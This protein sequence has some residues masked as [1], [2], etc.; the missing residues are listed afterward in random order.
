[1]GSTMTAGTPR[2]LHVTTSDMSLDLLLGPQLRAFG[3]AGYEVHTASAPG[4][5]VGSLTAAGIVHHPLRHAT[6]STAPHHDLL[7]VAELY[8][9]FRAVRP[10]IV[11]T[12]NPKPGV[13]GRLAARA[14]GIPLVVN[15]QHGLYA[16]PTDRLRRRLPVYALERVAAGF[17]DIELVQ[18]EEDV[19]TLRRLRVPGGK[20]Q[21]L[22]NGIDLTRFGPDPHA[23]DAVRGELGLRGDQLLVGTI[24]RLVR[25]KG[26]GDF[27]E[28]ARSISA[29]RDDTVFVVV[30]PEDPD[31]ADGISRE[32]I[33]RAAAGGIRFLG[34]RDDPER[35]YPAFD[36]F[37]LASW[38]E[39]FPRAAMEASAA[40]TPVVA[41]DIRGCRQVV[42]DGSTGLLVPPC[43]PAALAGA[44]STL[45]DDV[46]RRAGMGRQAIDRARREFDQ[47][48]CIERT[49]A[50]YDLLATPRRARGRRDRSRAA[51]AT[52]R[53]DGRAGAT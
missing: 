17:G 53:R 8:R 45:L 7:A 47:Q 1:M 52:A 35:L 27:L 23:R 43:D 46:D 16:Q 22:G 39:G 14:A 10:D 12:H 38:R 19:A 32:E 42:E 37:V 36:V 51:G 5:H 6:R 48:R 13:Y 20:L 44:I 40:G 26:I 15:T 18:N 30:G 24:G 21:L 41:T 2:L 29:Q 34:Y 25:E 3:A 11:H 9:L 33:D 4:P 31:K 50:A 49:L 28:A